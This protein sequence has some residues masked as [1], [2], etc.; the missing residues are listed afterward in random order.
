MVQCYFKTRFSI[1]TYLVLY[2]YK[3]FLTSYVGLKIRKKNAKYAKFAFILFLA[4]LEK[5]Y[6]SSGI[7]EFKCFGNLSQSSSMLEKI[8]YLLCCAK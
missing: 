7:A 6:N 3:L 4:A 8:G 5:Q 2:V 1:R